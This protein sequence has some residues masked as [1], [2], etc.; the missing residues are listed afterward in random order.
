MKIQKKLTLVAAFAALTL[1][2]SSLNAQIFE[3]GSTD[4]N[5][6]IGFGTAWYYTS[7]YKASMPFISVSGDYG[8]VDTWGPGVFGIGGLIG[9]NTYKSTYYYGTGDYGYKESNFTIAPRAT[10]HYQ[11]VDKLDTYGGV[12]SG[13]KIRSYKETGDY[14]GYAAPSNNVDFVFTVFAG[15]KYYFT[16]NFAV[17]SEI[18]VYDL[19]LFNIGVCLKLQ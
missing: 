5:F 16:D 12:I 19:A 8:L 7:S 11:F 13:V 4:L 18:Y 9:F 10:Y 6:Q 1:S 2:F 15:A 14:P 17:M 3:K